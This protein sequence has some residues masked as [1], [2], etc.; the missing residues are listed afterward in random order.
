MCNTDSISYHNFILHHFFF[1]LFL[2]SIFNKLKLSLYLFDSSVHC[3]NDM[4]DLFK[5][6]YVI[7]Q[8]YIDE[9]DYKKTYLKSSIYT[10]ILF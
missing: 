3:E 9:K 7:I 5:Q 4:I 6:N 1:T 10:I 8:I 2:S